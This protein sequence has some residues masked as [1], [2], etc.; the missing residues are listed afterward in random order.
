MPFSAIAGVDLNG[1]ANVTDYV[2]GTTRNVFNRGKD[3]EMMALVN[4]YRAANNLPALPV[5]QIDTN[6]FYALDL[7]VSK[8]IR[9]SNDRRVE[10]V[11]QVFNLLNR[12]NLL[13]S[14]WVTNAR[15]NTFGSSVSAGPMR[16]AEL[17]V[18][19]SF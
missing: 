13:A 3:A 5:S 10:L 12:K 2:P 16:Q 14:G 4:A 19:F 11:A 7:R 1:D 17:G 15:S 6:E 18:R 9:V 8:S